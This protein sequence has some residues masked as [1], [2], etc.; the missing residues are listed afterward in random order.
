MRTKSVVLVL[1]ALFIASTFSLSFGG[2][3]MKG[4][5]VFKDTNLGTNGKSC[6]SCHYKGSGIDGRKTEFTIMGKKK[7][8]I[9]DAVN[10]CI[11]VALKGK[12][13]PKDSQKMQDLVSYLKTLTGKKYKRKVIKGC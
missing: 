2:D 11:E 6:Y 9:E 7:A 3:V 12:P 8:S 4:V 5:E 1:I 13:L 10:F